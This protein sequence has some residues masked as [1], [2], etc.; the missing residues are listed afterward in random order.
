MI[1]GETVLSG[2]AHPGTVLRV[3]ESAAGFYLGFH[4]ADG[5]AYSRESEYFDSAEVA[6][7]VLL[8]LRS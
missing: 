7:A 1:D 5:S 4:D 2:A 3:C 8:H 6:A